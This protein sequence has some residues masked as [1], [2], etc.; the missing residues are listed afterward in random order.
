M[1]RSGPSSASLSEQIPCICCVC[2][3]WGSQKE[4]TKEPLLPNL[5]LEGNPQWS[6]KCPSTS[7]GRLVLSQVGDRVASYACFGIWEDYTFH[8]RRCLFS[9]QM[10]SVPGSP[11]KWRLLAHFLLTCSFAACSTFL[12]FW[13]RKTGVCLSY[14][15][16]TLALERALDKR[17]E[18]IEICFRNKIL[19]SLL[20]FPYETASCQLCAWHTIYIRSKIGWGKFVTVAGISVMPCAECTASPC[21]PGVW[22]H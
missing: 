22:A 4:R 15:V 6:I 5:H 17:Q 21:I 18:K 9:N 13:G 12:R 3:S 20:L 2:V 14:C 11:Q 19:L 10:L 1:G 8:V 7:L 16:N